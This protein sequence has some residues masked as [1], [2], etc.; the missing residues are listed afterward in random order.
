M[1]QRPGAKVWGTDICVP[2]SALTECIL[3]AEDLARDAPF[4]AAAIGHVGDGNFHTA[5]LIDPA[6]PDEL[7]QVEKITEQL[8]R[9]AI[10]LEGTC[11]GEHGIG[12]G[13]IKYMQDE[14]GDPAVALM[15]VLK[16]AI[17]PQNLFNPGKI[18]PD[19]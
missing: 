5:Y 11:T 7:A 1:A 8:V 19:P 10:Q 6:N 14:F 3:L 16:R 4:P 15:G 13:K 2:I 17:D 9:R 12:Y 18:L